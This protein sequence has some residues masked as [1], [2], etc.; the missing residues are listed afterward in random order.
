MK[1]VELKRLTIDGQL[2]TKYWFAVDI[3]KMKDELKILAPD[4]E[5]EIAESKRYY[6]K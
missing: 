5:P 6:N 1:S 3:N 4:I 2:S